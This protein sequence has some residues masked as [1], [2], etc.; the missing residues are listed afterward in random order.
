MPRVN[1]EVD[2]ALALLLDV[3]VTRMSVEIAGLGN[4]SNSFAVNLI[5]CL[6]DF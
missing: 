5:L 6:P 2:N 1:A 4:V 3:N